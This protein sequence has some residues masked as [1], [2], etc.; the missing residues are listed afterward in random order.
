MLQDNYDEMVSLDNDTF[1]N[2]LVDGQSFSVYSPTNNNTRQYTYS[3]FWVCI[4]WSVIC[5]VFA[6][7]KLPSW[8]YTH[9]YFWVWVDGKYFLTKPWCRGNKQS[10][11]TT[12]SNWLCWKVVFCVFANEQEHSYSISVGVKRHS[13]TVCSPSYKLHPSLYLH[14]FLCPNGH[15]KCFWLTTKNEHICTS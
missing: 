11:P 6:Q 5:C 3:Y 8:Q 9:S 10:F 13:S 2:S 15:A 14:L 12:S 7:R 1:L 4:E